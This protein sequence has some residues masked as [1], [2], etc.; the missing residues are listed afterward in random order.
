MGFKYFYSMNKHFIVFVVFLFC[1]STTFTQISGEGFDVKK[2]KIT[3]EV[4]D[5]SK[6][7]IHGETTI[8]FQKSLPYL[9]QLVLDFVPFDIIKVSF[10]HQQ[11][12]FDLQEDKIIIPLPNQTQTPELDS[13][14]IY[15]SGSTILD[16]SQWG[17][18][19]FNKNYVFNLG[20]GFHSNP[21]NYGRVW[22]PCV[23]NFEDRALYEVQIISPEKFTSY[24]GGI[25]TS[26]SIFNQKRYRTWNMTTEVPSYLASFTLGDYKDY[27]S[28]YSST[29]TGNKTP[30]L[31]AANPAL[32]TY[33]PSSFKNLHKAL[34]VYEHSFYPYQFQ[35]VG[36]VGVPFNGG[37]MEHACNIAYPNF[38]IDGSLKYET[39]MAHELAHHWWG[40]LVT[41][42]NAKEMWINEGMATYSEFLFTEKVYGK[43]AY[44]NDVMENHYNVLMS[45][46]SRDG[47]YY[48]L[49]QIPTEVTYGMHTYKKG[50]DHIRLLRYELGDSLFF[51]AM[52]AVMDNYKFDTI[53]TIEFHRFLKEEG[54]LVNTFFE[55]FMQQPGFPSAQLQYHQTVF[56]NDTFFS[57]L[58]VENDGDFNLH[59]YT[60]IPLNITIVYADSVMNKTMILNDSIESLTFSSQ[61][62]PLLV[63]LDDEG[64]IPFSNTTVSIQLKKADTINL[65]YT[66]LKIAIDQELKDTVD[67]TSDFYFF[68]HSQAQNN[69][70]VSDLNSWKITFDETKVDQMKGVFKAD[71]EKRYERDTLIDYLRKVKGSSSYKSL[72][73]LFYKRFPQDDWI[74]ENSFVRGTIKDGLFFNVENLKSGYYTVGFSLSN[75]EQEDVV[76]TNEALILPA[77][78]YHK[79]NYAVINSNGDEVLSGKIK[80]YKVDI[81]DLAS[82]HYFLLIDKEDEVQKQLYFIK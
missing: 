27:L 48:A 15:Y 23:D 4:D 13:I 70:L 5:A 8:Y 12:L 2:Y 56:E 72:I 30:I 47:G 75:F 77:S 21:H 82:G 53:G 19:Y 80:K 40:N 18:V 61:Q 33:V 28:T 68:N 37:A 42:A 38:A 81:E 31:I 54:Y 76:V 63:K 11:L 6:N 49:D 65:A 26:D 16:P 50:A 74:Q 32:I 59:R 36:Y 7:N 44:K 17:G 43:K 55:D 64:A 60:N 58:Q 20:V 79:Y 41:T 34:E 9:N 67:L 35:R 29:L 69:I 25:L 39:L 45:A 52:N 3:V 71:F 57:Q 1:V 51:N 66:N 22:F 24:A 14:T 46:A 73:N 10:H 62:L 78:T